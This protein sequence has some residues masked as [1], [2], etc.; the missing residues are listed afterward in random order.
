MQNTVISGLDQW[1]LATS[2]LER[3]LYNC[4]L[5][6]YNSVL[7]ACEKSGQWNS[8][9]RIFTQAL[10]HFKVDAFSYSA[11]ISACDSAL[12]YLGGE[13]GLAWT[14]ALHLEQSMA[15]VP[16][17]L[18]CY[19]GT[20]SACEKSSHWEFALHSF[21]QHI[22]RP[23]KVDGFTLNALLG[24]LARGSQW[25]WALWI[26]QGQLR[27]AN[28][29]SYNTAMLACVE[30]EQWNQLLQL[31]DELPIAADL[32]TM[33]TMASGSYSH[34]IRQLQV[35]SSYKFSSLEPDILTTNLQLSAAHGG[36][37]W[38]HALQCFLAQRDRNIITYNAS[39]KALGSASWLRSLWILQSLMEQAPRGLR[40]DVLT[41][42][43]CLASCEGQFLQEAKLL[44]IVSQTSL[45]LKLWNCKNWPRPRGS[46]TPRRYRMIL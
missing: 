38:H 31:L 19:N 42:E 40:G 10:Q 30:S 27:W 25:R 26:L 18:L 4:T 29:I 34:W 11:A 12:L 2:L 20:L 23:L 3:L 5:I 17:N 33:N 8:A 39:L 46:P 15:P 1:W 9:L 32:I 44:N 7:N 37:G 16:Q 45:E 24:A 22:N 41:F 28:I 14:R 43:A 21:L 6:T 13:K 35:L 36:N